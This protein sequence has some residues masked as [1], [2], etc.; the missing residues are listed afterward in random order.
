MVY[1]LS[2]FENFFCRKTKFFSRKYLTGGDQN[3]TIAERA[4][5]GEQE[6][7]CLSSARS[8]RTEQCNKPKKRKHL[9]RCRWSKEILIKISKAPDQPPIIS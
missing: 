4:K 2:V 9:Q 1:L 8:L 5:S 7:G 3:D 6:K